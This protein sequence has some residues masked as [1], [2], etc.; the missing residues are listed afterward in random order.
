[1]GR[2]SDKIFPFVVWGDEMWRGLDKMVPTERNNCRC[3]LPKPGQEKEDASYW[4]L[5]SKSI[6]LEMKVSK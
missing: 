1:M 3:D 2:N 4:T 6:P 5:V